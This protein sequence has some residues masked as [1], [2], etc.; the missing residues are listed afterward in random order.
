L[1]LPSFPHAILL[2]QVVKRP[3]AIAAI[4]IPLGVLE[5]ILLSAFATWHWV[6]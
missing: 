2:A 4:F 3:V 5:A 6:A 1:L